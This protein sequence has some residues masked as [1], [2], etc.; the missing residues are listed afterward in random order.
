MRPQ[1]TSVSA[2]ANSNTLPVDR[3]TRN[4]QL[5]FAVVLSAGASL[6][7]KVQH[8]FDDVQDS[9][10]TPT[11]FDHP[12]VTGQTANKDGNYAFPI[13]AVRLAVTSYTS[14]TATLTV[15]QASS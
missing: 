11:W 12:Y 4:F 2:A 9:T 6:I 13:T 3:S 14:G 7:Y 8:T 5:G 1:V 10:I 15:L